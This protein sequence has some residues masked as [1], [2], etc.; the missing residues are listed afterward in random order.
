MEHFI[1]LCVIICVIHLHSYFFKVH[2]NKIRIHTKGLSGVHSALKIINDTQKI[3]PV[4]KKYM[5]NQK[6][7]QS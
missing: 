3:T 7:Q 2:N 5:C 4:F 6:L 1:Q